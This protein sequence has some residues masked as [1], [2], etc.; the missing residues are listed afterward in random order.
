MLRFSWS[1][2]F[3]LLPLLCLSSTILAQE[4]LQMAPPSIPEVL[5][6]EP[7]DTDL[8]PTPPQLEWPALGPKGSDGTV[9]V[10]EPID[11][12]APKSE[13][14][15]APPPPPL[16]EIP[17]P[18]GPDPNE[19]KLVE[20]DVEIWRQQSEQPQIPASYTDRLAEAYVTGTEPVWLRV[21]FDPRAA[22]KHVWVR[23]GRGITV[24]LSTPVPTI[25]STGEVLVL[26]QLI[27]GVNRSHLIFSCEGVRTVLP[28][29]RAALSTVIEAEEASGGEH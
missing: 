22:G 1:R 28:V 19:V 5:P 24:N 3:L 4:Q 17:S 18:G 6:P 8:L 15:L 13:P 16:T 23:P 7:P 2:F 25:S 29:V 10:V 20:P 9:D 21:Q 12:P 27:E 14:S 11:V 26:A